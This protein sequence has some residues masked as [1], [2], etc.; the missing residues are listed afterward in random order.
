MSTYTSTTAG[1][2]DRA[3]T[4]QHLTWYLTLDVTLLLNM[5]RATV[6]SSPASCAATLNAINTL[7]VQRPF[8][9]PD[10][11]PAYPTFV[12][13]AYISSS[14]PPLQ[15][16]FVAGFSY[17]WNVLFRAT[18]SLLAGADP[19]GAAELFDSYI[20]QLDLYATTDVGIYNYIKF[21][22]CYSLLW[23]P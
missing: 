11:D 17:G 23:V 13:F 14:P 18:A 8:V 3:A 19:Q 20:T 2:M 10:G 22:Q 4:M 1:A 15:R 12:R 5:L 16:S 9:V 6:L 7:P 21:E